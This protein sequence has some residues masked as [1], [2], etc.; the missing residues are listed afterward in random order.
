MCFEH[1][2]TVGFATSYFNDFFK[3]A[4]VD[5]LYTNNVFERINQSV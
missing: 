4:L 5:V 1:Q 2:L 3:N